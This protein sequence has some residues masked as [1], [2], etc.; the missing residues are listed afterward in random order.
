MY[1]VRNIKELSYLYGAV[2]RCVL[3]GI[4]YCG[5]H[6]HAMLDNMDV[7]VLSSIPF[8]E[9]RFRNRMR[10]S[11]DIM[12]SHVPC[13]IPL[14]PYNRPYKLPIIPSYRALHKAFHVLVQKYQ[15]SGFFLTHTATYCS[16]YHT[17][18]THFE[19]MYSVRFWR[20]VVATI[21]AALKS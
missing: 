21:L 9:Q 19:V 1:V 8:A 10:Q 6:A 3:P 11:K 18:E 16:G 4:Y 13:R 20:G 14:P 17:G 5:V 7:V 12:A 2:S 15:V